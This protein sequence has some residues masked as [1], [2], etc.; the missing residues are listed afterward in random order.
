[1]MTPNPDIS[2]VLVN[3]SQTASQ[4]IVNRHIQLV[5]ED[6][7]DHDLQPIKRA[8]FGPVSLERLSIDFS[9]SY[10]VD[11]YVE[12]VMHPFETGNE[13]DVSFLF[14]ITFDLS[15]LPMSSQ[16]HR[17]QSRLIIT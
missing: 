6:D 13:H 11:L 14:L 2:A 5:E 9:R 8:P 3:Q 4:A 12:S 16:P 17:I 7:A 10:W 15:P 1:M